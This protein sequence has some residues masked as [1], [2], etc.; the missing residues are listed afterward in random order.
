M[1]LTSID[2]GQIFS[3]GVMGFALGLDAFSLGLGVGMRG[4]TRREIV[5]IS[6]LI[7]L[8]H[9]IMPWL[10]LIVGHTLNDIVGSVATILGGSLL[11][12]LGF[13]MVWSSFQDE[14]NIVDYSTGWGL[15]LFAMSV[16]VDAF[17]V[18]FS[19]GLF[20]MKVWLTVLIFGVLGG[21][22]SAC[23]LSLG[24]YAGAWLGEY[25][26]AVGGLILIAFGLK[27]LI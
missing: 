21:V 5:K 23:G 12:F 9:V 2:W 22:M 25:G 8:F 27:I 20:E 26:E 14:E 6:V 15:I 4:V 18:G 10:G 17:S 11:L 3:L 1:E 13:H 7:G 24:R 16:S 19:L